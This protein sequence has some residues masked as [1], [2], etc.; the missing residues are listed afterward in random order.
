MTPINI[1]FTTEKETKGT[2]KLKECNA[3][4]SDT[5]AAKVGTLYVKKSNFPDG[6]VPKLMAFSLVAVQDVE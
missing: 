3:D 5:F 6:K 2:I 4:G 1:F